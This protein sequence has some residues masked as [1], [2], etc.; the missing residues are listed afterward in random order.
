MTMN[1][2]ATNGHWNIISQTSCV[3]VDTRVS[4]AQD[5]QTAAHSNRKRKQH[6]DGDLFVGAQVDALVIPRV[7]AIMDGWRKV[8]EKLK[9]TR[10]QPVVG[11]LATWEVEGKRSDKPSQLHE[12]SSFFS[13]RGSNLNAKPIL[14][15]AVVGKDHTTRLICDGPK[16]NH[17]QFTCIH[18][19]K[20]NGAVVG[21]EDVDPVYYNAVHGG[22][23]DDTRLQHILTTPPEFGPYF[24][25][26]FS[27]NL[28][29]FGPAPA[30]APATLASAS[31][32]AAPAATNAAP[33]AAVTAPSQLTTDV[34]AMEYHA[35]PD[36][37]PVVPERKSIIRETPPTAPGTVRDLVSRIQKITDKVEGAFEEFWEKVHG[38]A[39][40][41][42][43]DVQDIVDA[44][45]QKRI[46]GGATGPLDVKPG[47]KRTKPV[48]RFL[49]KGEY[50]YNGFGGSGRRKTKQAKKKK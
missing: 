15:S 49:S 8:I 41:L 39:V 25:V 24:T 20:L 32:N 42:E 44:E 6:R 11:A 18:K 22:E 48:F 12:W 5:R 36:D 26:P 19:C 40:D 28:D 30:G 2:F 23:L 38:M 21:V 31:T 43:E 7:V 14:V 1:S 9:V 34:P 37:G 16:C 17:E 4:V 45:T 29:S 46:D 3:Q 50:T 27:G 10:V 33:A 47:H 35:M 13:E